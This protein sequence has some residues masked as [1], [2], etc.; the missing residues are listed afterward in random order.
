MAVG[1]GRI[2]RLWLGENSRGKGF[3]T[4][5]YWGLSDDPRLL[6]TQGIA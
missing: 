6:K 1:N 3:Q 2:V 5:L 4:M